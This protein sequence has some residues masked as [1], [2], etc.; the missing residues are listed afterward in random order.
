MCPVEQRG[1][2]I[3]FR[4]RS[5][6]AG[7]HPE[8][9]EVAQMDRFSVGQR[10]IHDG[11]ESVEYQQDIT[12]AGSAVF[13]DTAANTVQVD[14]FGDAGLCIV[15]FGPFGRIL[16]HVSSFDKSEF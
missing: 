4:R 11:Q 12:A 1:I 3:F 2:E 7:N 10:F 5:F 6:A 15:K 9:A 16:T 13:A 8:A 14:L